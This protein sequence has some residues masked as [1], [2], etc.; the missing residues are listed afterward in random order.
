[1][2]TEMTTKIEQALTAMLTDHYSYESE[3]EYEGG[4]YIEGTCYHDHGTYFYAY[5]WNK[6]RRIEASVSV[7]D[8]Y[9]FLHRFGK[10]GWIG[11][12]YSPNDE[13]EPRR[14]KVTETMTKALDK[15][16]KMHK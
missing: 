10:K 14:F 8:G 13:E 7:C 9:S 2:T 6:G 16:A 11:H 5:N 4:N 12:Y 3:H 15:L 1:M